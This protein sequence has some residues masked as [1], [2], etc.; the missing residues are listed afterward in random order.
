MTGLVVAIST[1]GLVV[2]LP[3]ADLQVQLLIRSIL[4]HRRLSL[5]STL[6]ARLT[7]TSGHRKLRIASNFDGAFNYQAGVFYFKDDFS[8]VSSAQSAGATAFTAGSKSDIENTAWAIFAQASYEVSEKP[9]PDF[10]YSIFG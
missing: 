1:A 9:R 8:G 6:A 2:C 5:T 7:W 3:V 10:W 4:L